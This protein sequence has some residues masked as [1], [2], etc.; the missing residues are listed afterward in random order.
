MK[1]S[2]RTRTNLEGRSALGGRTRGSSFT[3]SDFTGADEEEDQRLEVRIFDTTACASV[4]EFAA[5]GT[6]ADGAGDVTLRP[7]LKRRENS[8]RLKEE[9]K[10]RTIQVDRLQQKEEELR[11][12]QRKEDA[13]DQQ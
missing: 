5:E 11:R 12:K 4:V 13:A 3:V 10:E 1:P 2:S 9:P 7:E 8:E 6:T